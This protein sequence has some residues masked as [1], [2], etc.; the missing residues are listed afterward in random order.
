[1]QDVNLTDVHWL[2]VNLTD[3][4]GLDVNLTDVQGL[5]VTL[6]DVQR[7]DV[8][9]TDVQ[10]LDVYWT[11]IVRQRLTCLAAYTLAHAAVSCSPF[12]ILRHSSRI[13]CHALE[14]TRF[15][16]VTVRPSAFRY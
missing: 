10:R 14:C 7:L 13:W 2:D 8:N 15:S 6:T 1:M 12:I 3:V 16:I 9:L 11:R 5:D 4:Q